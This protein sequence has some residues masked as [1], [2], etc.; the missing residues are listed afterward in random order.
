MSLITPDFGLLFWM[1]LI[2]AVVFFILAKFGFPVITD[3]IQARADRIDQSIRLAKEAEAE[4]ASLKERQ[5]QIL[6]DAQ[7]EQVLIQMEGVRLKDEMIA[8]ARAAAE[9]ESARIIEK[10]RRQIA[11]E[12]DEAIRQIRTTVAGLSIGIAE[13]VLR[14]NLD[15]IDAQTEYVDRLVNEIKSSSSES[16]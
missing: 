13:K 3:M 6:D 4:L 11:A 1:T 2:F 12:R 9:E 8:K 15:N 16:N 10:A 5:Q 7:R 14:K